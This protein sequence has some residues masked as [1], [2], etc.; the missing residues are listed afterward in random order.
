MKDNEF[1]KSLKLTESISEI[2]KHQTR[3]TSTEA[4]YLYTN[5]SLDEIF[6]FLRNFYQENPTQAMIESEYVKSSHAEN[7]YYSLMYELSK[8]YTN[9]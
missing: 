6:N 8:A 3:N 4:L 5:N 9:F 7:Y 2:Q 1:K